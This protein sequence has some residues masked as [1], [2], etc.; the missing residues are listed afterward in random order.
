[1]MVAAVALNLH[2][3]EPLLMRFVPNYPTSPTIQ[4]NA[5]N[6]LWRLA[7]RADRPFPLD[8]AHPTG[9][10]VAAIQDW[11]REKQKNAPKGKF[12]A[13]IEMILNPPTDEVMPV[14][15][16]GTLPR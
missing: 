16:Y 6:A 7:G 2:E 5:I 14:E 13:D 4:G 1:M 11:W 3:A 9:D 12:D 10:E 15:I 8:I